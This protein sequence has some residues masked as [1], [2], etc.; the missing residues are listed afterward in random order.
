MRIS[1]FQYNESGPCARAE[2]TLRETP[3]DSSPMRQHLFL[4]Q[5]LALGRLITGCWTKAG[6]HLEVGFVT[7]NEIEVY[8]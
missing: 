8:F 4:C 6:L 5:L 2:S 7:E 3:N 1:D